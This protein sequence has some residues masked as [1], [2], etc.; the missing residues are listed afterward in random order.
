MPQKKTT[1]R[2]LREAKGLLESDGSVS[3]REHL[4]RIAGAYQQYQDTVEESGKECAEAREEKKRRKAVFVDAM[5]EGLPTPAD[6]EAVS[7]KL[8][9]VELAWQD[10][11]E[12]EALVRERLAMRKDATKSARLELDRAIREARQPALP[13]VDAPPALAVVDG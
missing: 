6:F 5:A 10:L 13:G 1:S 11:E 7:T 4:E 2:E 8:H 9:R 12:A 3:A